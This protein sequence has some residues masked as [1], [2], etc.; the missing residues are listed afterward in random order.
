MIAT[1]EWGFG[2]VAAFVVCDI[3]LGIIRAFMQGS[4][5]SAELRNG[6]LRKATYFIILLLLM[7]L[8][9]AGN[10]YDDMAA[11]LSVPVFQS[12]VAAMS[13]VEVSSIIENV[14]AIVPDLQNAPF[15]KN[16]KGKE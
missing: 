11:I 9:I 16:F 12:A 3:V 4:F 5:K 13:A 10:Y 15:F 7:F 14:T 8:E 1:Y 2:I 6:L